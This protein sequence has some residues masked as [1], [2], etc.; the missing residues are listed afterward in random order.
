MTFVMGGFGAGL[1]RG[2]GVL[3]QS[4]T[5]LGCRGEDN[6]GALRRGEENGVVRCT[7]DCFDNKGE[8]RQPVSQF[9]STQ[10]CVPRQSAALKRDVGHRNGHR[11]AAIQVGSLAAYQ[12]PRSRPRTHLDQCGLRESSNSPAGYLARIKPTNT[13][14]AVVKLF[15]NNRRVQVPLF[16]NL[17]GDGKVE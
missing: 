2:D 5:K 7:T 3:P 14:H 12:L 1:N 17:S 16:L 15:G 10:T 9:G 6:R 8:L 4:K 11:S 13:R